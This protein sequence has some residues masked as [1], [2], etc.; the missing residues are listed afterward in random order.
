MIKELKNRLNGL[1]AEYVSLFENKH[2]L[3]FDFWV[4]T[5]P[6][7][8]GCFGDY[9]IDFSTIRYDLEA[10]LPENLFIEWYDITLASHTR[11]EPYINYKSYVKSITK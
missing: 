10:E 9:Y 6:G 5:E 7:T 3:Q 4:S 11:E 1:I 8:I 2:N